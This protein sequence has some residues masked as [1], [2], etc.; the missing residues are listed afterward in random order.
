MIDMNREVKDLVE[1]LDDVFEEKIEDL[2]EIG[3]DDRQHNDWLSENGDTETSRAEYSNMK[4]EILRRT[5][6]ELTTRWRNS[7]KLW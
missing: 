6:E 3:F 5:L 7:S 2:L 1:A 4:D